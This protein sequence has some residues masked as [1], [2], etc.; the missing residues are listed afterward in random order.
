MQ[1]KCAMGDI[2]RG[3]HSEPYSTSVIGASQQKTSFLAMC[4]RKNCKIGG[5]FQHCKYVVSVSPSAG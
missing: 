3:Y 1:D 5:A 2:R 4:L